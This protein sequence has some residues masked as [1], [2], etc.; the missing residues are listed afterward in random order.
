MGR[1]GEFRVGV[2]LLVLSLQLTSCGIFPFLGDYRQPDIEDPRACPGSNVELA[3]IADHFHIAIPRDARNVR[4]ASDLLPLDGTFWWNAY[5]ETGE[6]EFRRLI[7]S[8]GMPRLEYGGEMDSLETETACALAPGGLH[9]YLLSE[10]END[11][12]V[13]GLMVEESETT[14]FKVFVYAWEKP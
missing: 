2:G 7:A 4:F 13:R 3:E 12:W 9:D 8:S 5:F 14:D 10:E 11:N 6:E 1:S